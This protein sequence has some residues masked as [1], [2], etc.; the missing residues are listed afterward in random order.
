MLAVI[1]R[2]WLPLTLLV[3]VGT[4]VALWYLSPEFAYRVLAG[5]ERLQ[6][7]VFKSD[8]MIQERQVVYFQGGQGE[9]LLLLH[10]FMGSKE[11]WTPIAGALSRHFRVTAPDLPGFGESALVAGSDYSIPAQ[12]ERIRVFADALGLERFWLGGSSMGGNI[13]GAFAARYPERVRGLWLIAPLGVAGAE[14]SG[15]DRLR[16]ARGK[17]PLIIERPGQFEE[18][19]SLVLE[20]RPW[21]PEPAFEFLARDAASRYRHYL[22]VDGQIHLPGGTGNRPATPLEPLL[23]GSQIPTLIMWGDKDRVLHVSGARVLADVMPNAEVEIMPGVGHLPMLEKPGDSTRA[24][25]NFVARVR[26]ARAEAPPAPADEP[27]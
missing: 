3:A 17:P 9:D 16:D 18:I 14:P 24:F 27:S 22:W 6:A 19:V 1:K 26:A 2:W 10:G 21:I 20:E 5:T 8:V 15:I 12:V 25:L 4:A 7:G 23:A 11:H 13:A